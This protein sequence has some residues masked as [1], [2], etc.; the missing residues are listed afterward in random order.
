MNKRMAKGKRWRMRCF[1]SFFLM[2]VAKCGTTDLYEALVRHPQIIV[3]ELKEP[4]YWSRQ[5]F[6]TNPWLF[7]TECPAFKRRFYFK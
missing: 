3:S 6:E 5:R 7:Q 4:E 1:P 2:G